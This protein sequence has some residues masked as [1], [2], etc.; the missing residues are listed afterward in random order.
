MPF[1]LQIASAAS[2]YFNQNVKDDDVILANYNSNARILIG[3]TSNMPACL[4]LDSNVATFNGNVL[5]THIATNTM[6]S[7]S[8]DLFLPSPSDSYPNYTMPG[9]INDAYY[10]SNAIASVP[11]Q[12]DGSNALITSN[13]NIT[14]NVNVQ[15]GVVNITTTETITYPLSVN[16][17]DANGVSIFTSGDIATFSDARL[18]TNV[19]E[20][21]NAMSKINRIGGYTYYRTDDASETKQCGLIAQEVLSVLPESVRKQPDSEYLTVSYG[22]VVAL[23]VQGIKELSREI[24]ELKSLN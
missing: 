4:E 7:T 19:K 8:I 2:N 22:N 6:N 15:D 13:L 17:N 16:G 11:I 9:T 14:S 23:L 12:L 3:N 1:S 10:A 5:S 18:K 24:E 20:I 21:D